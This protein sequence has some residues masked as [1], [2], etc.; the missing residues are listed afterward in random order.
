MPDPV[1]SQCPFKIWGPDE[2]WFTLLLSDNRFPLD[3]KGKIHKDQDLPLA[4]CI[5]EVVKVM[6]PYRFLGNMSFFPSVDMFLEVL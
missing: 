6:T 1:K 2:L 5:V 3:S 4:T